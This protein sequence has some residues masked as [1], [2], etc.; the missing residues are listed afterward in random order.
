MVVKCRENAIRCEESGVR[1]QM[2]RKVG[3]NAFICEKS[4]VLECGGCE[5]AVKMRSDARSAAC[6]NAKRVKNL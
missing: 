6:V 1:I 2:E 4:S 3:E 5:K